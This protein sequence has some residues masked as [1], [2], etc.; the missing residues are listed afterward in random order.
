MTNRLYL[1]LLALVATVCAW[2][3]PQTF[4]PDSWTL[5]TSGSRT[6]YRQNDGLEMYKH[7]KSSAHF[8]LYYGVDY[9]STAP[10]K[11]NSSDAL[12]VDCQD[13]LNKAEQFYDEN[14]TQMKFADLAN[15]KLSQHK[16]IIVILHDAG[17]TATGSGYDDQ[18]GALWVTP[19]TCKPVGFVIAHE[20]GHAFQYQVFA[21][22]GGYAGFRGAIGKGGTFWEQCAQWQGSYSYLYDAINEASS[23]W[24]SSHQLAF[25]HEA[26]RY[27]SFFL[28]YYLAQHHGI[29]I[30]GR[31]FR[32]DA[33][34]VVDPLQAYMAVTGTDV[35]SL[36]R[37][38]YDYAAHTATFD[39][40]KI[41]D[42]CD[43]FGMVGDYYDYNSVALSDG[44]VQVAYASAPSATGF[45]VVPLAVPAAGTPLRVDFTA[46]KA[47]GASLASGDPKKVWTCD[48]D[49]N[50]AYTTASVSKYNTNARYADRGFRLGYV[51]LLADGTRVYSSKDRVY[52]NTNTGGEETASLYFTVPQGTEHLY[53][54]V[55]PA[56]SS[57]EPHPWTDDYK[58]DDQWPYR[59]HFV[60]TNIQGGDIIYGDAGTDPDVAGDDGGDQPEPTPTPD[61]DPVV[62]PTPQGGTIVL[63]GSTFATGDAATWTFASGATISN[64]DG[65]SKAVGLGTTLKYPNGKTFTVAAP[66]GSAIAAVTFTGFSNNNSTAAT[67]A[68]DGQATGC[69]L[70]AKTDGS[71]AVDYNHTF[72]QP[73]SSF[74]FTPSPKEACLTLTLTLAGSGSGSGD[75]QADTPSTT[76]HIG[77]RGYATFY[78]P[79]GY[80][81]PW[82]LQGYTVSST[83]AGTAHLTMVYDSGYAVPAATPLVLRGAEG[84]YTVEVKT[85]E[86]YEPGTNLLHGMATTGETPAIVGGM[87]YYKLCYSADHAGYGFYWGD[88]AGGTF[89]MHAG[90]C[91]LALPAAAAARAIALDFGTT[92]AIGALAA[93]ASKTRNAKV[94]R[95][96]QVI[97]GGYNALGQRVAAGR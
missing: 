41:R 45:N 20:I 33:G 77:D 53:L 65:K 76:V 66:A 34:Y 67:L 96:G 94:L 95:G 17:W 15:S 27:E 38:L 42:Q 40:N 16:M 74:T 91:Y 9:G 84:D 21:D 71:N 90:R 79:E 64:A 85:E 50:K 19:S 58:Q 47:S 25:T 75:Q 52:C 36:Y 7:S 11:L 82:G 23:T 37:M 73:V 51:A 31:M 8:D 88:P 62:P 55:S 5:D 46:L 35:P 68:V 72:P 86:A 83:S 39:I 2:G 26:Q 12:Y 63:D 48:D 78:Y 80:I 97:V 92:T 43:Q 30:I 14:I 56:P 10:D 1:L 59:L 13:L 81:M 3:S 89:T 61:P 44:G 69:T 29:D 49:F 60:N 28:H 6:V 87:H 70:P 93:P 57:Y 24:R 54:I 32:Y 4:Y 22:L 18:I